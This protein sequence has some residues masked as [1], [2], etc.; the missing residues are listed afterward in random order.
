MRLVL[1]W[2]REAPA[3]AE[4]LAAL[5]AE[6][7]LGGAEYGDRHLAVYAPDDE[8][9]RARL[10]ALER[11]ARR[12]A[13]EFGAGEIL[14]RRAPV[15]EEDWAEAWKR[16]YRPLRVGRLWLVPAWEA[17]PP[18]ADGPVV[19]LDPG[20]AFGTGEHASTRL[21]LLEMQDLWP[22]LPAA[23]RVADVGSGSGVL[24]VAAAVLSCGAARVTAVDIDPVAVRATRANAQLNEVELDARLGG[25]EVLPPYAF[26]LIL[27]NLTLDIHRAVAGELARA[28]AP[29]GVVVASGIVEDQE[30]EARA[31]F[32]RAGLLAR[33]ARAADGW[34]SLVLTK[35]GA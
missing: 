34:L 11:E 25:P 13:A 2:E 35:D 33:R 4:G 32:A 16:Y 15:R 30:A 26:D 23:P 5:A 28:A 17:A 19:R 6:A 24:A 1:S 27:A 10:F 14:V 29:G 31:A 21:C 22:R 3:L 18:A 20:M 7:G 9:G 8:D 12:W